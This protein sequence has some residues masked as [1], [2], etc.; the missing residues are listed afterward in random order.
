MAY[1]K[2]QVLAYILFIFTLVIFNLQE[3]HATCIAWCPD[4]GVLACDSQVTQGHRKFKCATKIWYSK[5]RKAYMAAAGD[6][7]DIM[8]VKKWFLD[9]AK[10]NDKNADIKGEFDVLICY[11]SGQAQYYDTDMSKEPVDIDDNFALGSGGDFAMA[12]MAC[13]KDADEAVHIASLLDIGTND[14][15]KKYQVV[16]WV[17]FEDPKSLPHMHVKP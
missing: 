11:E 16:H 3:A 15:I 7:S 9:P 10:Q 8:K 14:N 2:Y 1:M 13:G 12:A 4:T 6:V 5:D 17:P